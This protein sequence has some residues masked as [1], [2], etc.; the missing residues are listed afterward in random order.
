MYVPFPYVLIRV[1]PLSLCSLTYFWLVTT[2]SS[3]SLSFIP[4]TKFRFMYFTTT[5]TTTTKP[6]QISSC[7]I[8]H[9]YRVFSWLSSSGK[10]T[11]LLRPTK[12][13]EVY[14]SKIQ[15]LHITHFRIPMHTPSFH[16]PDQQKLHVISACIT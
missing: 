7:S 1:S 15:P 11:L 13:K 8:L 12:P 16:K 4:N 5:T 6:N 10:S 3:F 2:Y 14:R 9:T